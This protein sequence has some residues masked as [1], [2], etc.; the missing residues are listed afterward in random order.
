MQLLANPKG[1]YHFLSGID[2]YS[3]GVV[4][5]AGHEVVHATLRTPLPW[6][7]GFE[8]IDAHLAAAARSRHALCGIQLRSPEPFTMA[9]FIEFNVGYCDLVKSWDLYVGDLNPIARTNVAPEDFPPEA[10]SLHAFSYTVPAEPEAPRTFVVAGA[11]ELRAAALDADTIVRRGEVGPDAMREKARHVVAIM[12]ERLVGL[13][14]GWDQITT[15]DLYTVHLLEGLLEDAVLPTV[16]PAARHGMIWIP[17]RPPI[18]E[19]EFEMDLR[20]VRTQITL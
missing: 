16:G 4:A 20:G 9:G 2:P 6:R 7:E 8:L 13:G 10:V 18:R 17:S 19:I 12:E 11:G 1:N 3:C 15:T 14:A 5:D